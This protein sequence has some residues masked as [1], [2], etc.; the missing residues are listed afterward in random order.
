MRLISSRTPARV[1][2]SFA[3]AGILLA[4]PIEAAKKEYSYETNPVRLGLNALR[5][6]KV[7]EARSHFEEAI[8]NEH[9]ISRARYGL[10]EV[11]VRQGKA[12]EAE[13]LYRQ[14]LT[15]ASREKGGAFPEAHAGLGLLLLRLG[16][17]DE[18][19]AEIAQAL[20]EKSDLWD[21]QYARS[22]L[23]IEEGKLAEAEEFL[24]NG[25]K[26][27]GLKEGEDRYRYALA[28]LLEAR[29]DLEGAER[30]GLLATTLNPADPDYAK[31]VAD[32]YL[33]RGAFGLAA[34][35]YEKVLAAPGVAPTAQFY[36]Q[37]GGLYEQLNEPNE[38]LRRY[39]EAVKIDSTY[40]P[41]LKDMGRLYSLSK[42]PEKAF[43]AYSLY[44]QVVQDDLESLV[45]LA[46]SALE[47]RRF[48]EALEA[49]KSSF[50]RDSTRA[51]IR[52]LYA[53]AAAQSKESK[54]AE[55]LYAGIEDRTT[56]EAIDH[57]RL[58]HIAYEAKR[59][60]EAREHLQQGVA[61]DSTSA[62]GY[63]L[64]GLV[65][66]KEDDPEAAVQALEKATALAPQYAP[67]ALNLGVALLQ[68][69]RPHDGIAVLRKA[70]ALAPES[71]QVLISLAQALAAA[72][73]TAAAIVEYRRAIELD[74]SNAKAYRG[75]G[76]CQIQRKSYGEAVTSLKQATALESGN[77]D[78]WAMLGQAYLG[79]NDVLHAKQAAERCLALNP[80]HPTG[81]SVLDVSRQAQSAKASQ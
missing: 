53:R 6:G 32:I 26:K 68:A 34:Q 12:V 81:R 77:A 3:L 19:K 27:K 25:K 61:L 71:P 63:Y 7:E 9:E 22:L 38:A 74:E 28:R 10:A 4:S 15:E 72:D 23:A 44:N 64:L 20:K 48:K 54:L 21:V 14:A 29:A 31:L 30:E 40:A 80:S 73:S 42:I 33:R 41:A 18:A 11:A 46:R 69:K 55:E 59:L 45:N 16:R 36:H 62:E 50:A 49:A 13:A 43:V 51:D 60:D 37:L 58:G 70:Q 78:A 76:L 2:A 65:E 66:L 57:V 24:K 67:A 52:L 8:A 56:L 79:L 5:E 39:Q 35:T 75:L 1:A 17:L 47:V